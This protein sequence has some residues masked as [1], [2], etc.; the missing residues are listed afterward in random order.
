[1]LVAIEADPALLA[2]L[3]VELSGGNWKCCVPLVT[4]ALGDFNLATGTP[5]ECDKTSSEVQLRLK[6]I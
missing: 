1:M 4:G 6:R 3:I 5:L 2:V